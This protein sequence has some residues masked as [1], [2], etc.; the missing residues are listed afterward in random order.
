[1]ATILNLLYALVII[2]GL[3]C[4]VCNA[5][6]FELLLEEEAECA[7]DCNLI[8]QRRNKT[9][10]KFRE[11]ITIPAI[12]VV[13]FNIFKDGRR[14]PNTTQYLYG[15]SRAIVGE[16]IFSLPLDYIAACLYLPLVFYEQQQINVTESKQ[17]CLAAANETC[18]QYIIFQTLAD[19]TKID[20]CEKENCDTLCR[21]RF[22]PTDILAFHGEQYS[23]CETGDFDNNTV[24]IDSCLMPNHR[25]IFLVL[26]IAITVVSGLSIIPII[27]F[28]ANRCVRWAGR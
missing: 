13:Y 2:S 28:I 21:R 7:Q 8:I 9:Y 3:C 6:S 25:P 24:N 22:S 16:P 1:M 10:D 27:I 23:C 4:Q 12:R 19:F 26:N 14:L 20:S 15:W 18:R 5:S 17:G 11:K